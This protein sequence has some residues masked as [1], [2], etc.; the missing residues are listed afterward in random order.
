MTKETVNKVNN[1]STKWEKIL[2]EYIPGKGL[3]SKIYKELKKLN[4]KKLNN[5]VSK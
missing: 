2:A 3:E 1:Q 5:S 4:S